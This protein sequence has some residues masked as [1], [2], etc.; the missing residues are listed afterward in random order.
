MWGRASNRG[1]EK[2]LHVLRRRGS[3]TWSLTEQAPPAVYM[4]DSTLMTEVTEEL[5]DHFWE[6]ERGSS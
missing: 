5:S 1:H 4:I 6:T 2:L 3:R